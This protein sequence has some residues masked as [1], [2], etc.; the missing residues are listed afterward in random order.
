MLVILVATAVTQN[1]P[2]AATGTVQG[3]VTREGTN[4]P[5]PEVE[6]QIP[7][8]GGPTMNLEQAQSLVTYVNQGNTIPREA[9]EQARDIVARVAQGGAPPQL[10]P[11]LKATTDSNGHFSISNVPVGETQVVAQLAGFFGPGGNGYNPISVVRVEVSAQQTESVRLSMIPG[12]T[13]TGRI[14]GP[15]GKPLADAMILVLQQT[16]RFGQAQLDRAPGVVSGKTTDDRG[17]YR[18]YRL[19]PGEYFIGVRAREPRSAVANVLSEI[20]LPTLYPGVTD[21]SRA[22]PIVLKGG[23]ELTG[24]NFQTITVPAATIR[25]KVTSTFPAV[26]LPG[27]RGGIR[28]P[29]ATVSIVA[30]A[31]SLAAS[32]FSMTTTAGPD[33]SFEISGIAS[34]VYDLIARLPA[35]YGWAN[36]NPP[37]RALA[38]W[39]FGRTTVEVRGANADNVSI[40][41]SPGVDVPGRVMVDGRPASPAMSLT[42]SPDYSVQLVSDEQTANSFGQIDRYK[43]NIDQDG[44][45]KF[46]VLPEGRYRVHV[47]LEGTPGTKS[48]PA[49]SPLP[50]NAYLADVRQNGVHVYDNGLTVTTQSANPLEVLINTNGGVLNG[51]VAGLD[52]GPAGPAETNITAVLVPSEDRRQNPDLYFV[53]H[54][55][56]GNRGRFAFSSVPPGS[57]KLFAWANVKSGAYENAEFLRQYENR[58]VPVTVL[59]NAVVAA[60]VEVIP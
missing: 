13:V 3:I 4:D 22:I 26:P 17:E 53:A 20:S 44:S 30:R 28:Q 42:L 40:V 51:H 47:S 11:P 12:G 21:A 59:A 46:P 43:V 24:V 18:L 36:L 37:E 15:D 60:E 55:N 58:G 32:G 56:A 7:V 29:V 23:D 50:R 39:A 31:G 52:R 9:L 34:G 48:E 8:R 25:G 38:A 2:P 27:A 10:I 14:L 5:I 45:F 54:T 19:P 57:Y 1:A 49:H 33:G 16:Y 41:V 6:I 35:T